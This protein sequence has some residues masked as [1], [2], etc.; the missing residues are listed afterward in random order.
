MSL[1][2]PSLRAAHPVVLRAA[3]H[4]PAGHRLLVTRARQAHHRP[5]MGRLLVTLV[6]LPVM[7]V[8]HRLIRTRVPITARTITATARIGGDGSRATKER[9]ARRSVALT[10]LVG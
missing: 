7:P 8:R 6:R 10:A 4:L 1:P 2:R 5:A 3:R 9:A